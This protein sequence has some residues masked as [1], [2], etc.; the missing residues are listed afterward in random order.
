MVFLVL[1]KIFLD[2]PNIQYVL[3]ILINIQYKLKNKTNGNIEFIR[4]ISCDDF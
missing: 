2:I 4:F 1:G 3:A